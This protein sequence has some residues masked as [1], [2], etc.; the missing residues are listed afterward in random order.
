MCE[1]RP[2]KI[3]VVMKFNPDTRTVSTDGCISTPKHA[4]LGPLNID[5]EKADSFLSKA[6]NSSDLDNF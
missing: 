5:L 2:R 4:H 3:G 6:V 1:S